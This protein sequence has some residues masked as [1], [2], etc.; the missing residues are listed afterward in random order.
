MNRITKG[1]LFGFTLSALVSATATAQL[2]PLPEGDNGIAKQFP[3]DTNIKSH[4]NV[5]FADNFESYGSTSQLTSNW[6]N[7]YQQT[8]TRIATEAANVFSGTRS[9]E[10]RIPQTSSEV[11]NALIKNLSPT[12]DTVFV[13]VY[14]K[15]ETGFN[16]IGSSH[17]GIAIKAKYCCP[18]VPANGTN[19]FYVD[20]ENSRDSTSEAIPGRTHI[21]TYHP[22]Q[23]DQ[24]GDHFF[25]DGTVIPYSSTP[26]NFGPYFVPRPNFTPEVNRWYSYEL[27]VKANTPGLRD[28][29]I[30]V[31]IDGKLIADFPNLRLRDTTNLKIDQ[32]ELG[33]HVKSNTI[34][35]N[36]KWYDDVVIARS[37]IGPKAGTTPKVAP[38]TNL[39]STV[40]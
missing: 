6:S 10:F 40:R 5:I 30:A 18:G 20:V 28:G 11:S 24:W 35:Q 36:L 29:R 34:R 14:T 21:Y 8:Y 23:R 7:V 31:W 15:F 12:E 3:S 39:T 1:I 37:Y 33:L 9:L 2:A 25:P 27:M 4:P 26:G 16:A 13:R 32:V 17:N 22:D 38:P 19:K